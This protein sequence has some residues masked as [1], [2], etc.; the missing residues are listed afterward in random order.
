MENTSQNL[1]DPPGRF[2]GGPKIAQEASKTPE[3]HPRG[4]QER[5]RGAQEAPKSR[6]KAPKRRPTMAKD[7]PR[8]AREAPRTPQNRFPASPR[9]NFLHD[10]GGKLCAKGLWNEFS[11]FFSLPAMLVYAKNLEKAWEKLWFLHIWSSC[12]PPARVHAKA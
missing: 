7:R 3:R 6:P 9:A 1:Q 11:L 4:A 10:L 12:S 2:P 8:D 5:P